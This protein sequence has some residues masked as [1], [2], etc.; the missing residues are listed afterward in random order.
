MAKQSLDLGNELARPRAFGALALLAACFAAQAACTTSHG[1]QTADTNTS[2]LNA[3]TDDGACT[4]ATSCVGYVCTVSCSVEQVGTCRQL[5]AGAVCDALSATCDLPCEEDRDCGALGSTLVCETGRCREPSGLSASAQTLQLGTT[6]SNADLWYVSEVGTTWLGDRWRIGVQL[7]TSTGEQSKDGYISSFTSIRSLD[8]FPDEHVERDA[9]EDRSEGV[10]PTDGDFGPLLVGKDGRVMEHVLIPNR[11]LNAPRTCQVR[12]YGPDSLAQRD[13]WEYDCTR[14]QRSI[15]PLDAAGSWLLLEQSFALETVL[16]ARRYQPGQHL[17][18]AP[19][20]LLRRGDGGSGVPALLGES[21][22]QISLHWREASGF[23]AVA[24][25]SE[26]TLVAAALPESAWR[27]ASTTSL[28]RSVEGDLFG[29]RL[30]G[31]DWLLPISLGRISA[32]EQ[33]R[34]RVVAVHLGADAGSDPS[35]VPLELPLDDAQ[36]GEAVHSLCPMPER[37]LLGY[38]HVEVPARDA[39]GPST[40]WLHVFDEQGALRTAPVRVARTDN[41]IEACELSWSGEAFLATWTERTPDFVKRP[42]ARVIALA[43]EINAAR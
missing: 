34:W 30:M 39:Q 32:D 41:E 23:G 27:D 28:P 8:V 19:V 40:L 42:F 37:K 4:G 36:L 21:D 26:N 17:L 10:F 29:W 35:L 5:G 7:L 25:L 24:T 13:V 18:G 14:S 3:C 1:P 12:F 6:D 33:G 43:P 20:E 15:A 16:S 22:G 31:D 9:T 2:W 11:D 38:C